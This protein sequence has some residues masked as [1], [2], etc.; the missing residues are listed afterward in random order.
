MDER[1]A[2]K[3][4]RGNSRECRGPSQDSS[5]ASLFRPWRFGGLAVIRCSTMFSFDPSRRSVRAPW[6]SNLIRNVQRRSEMFNTSEFEQTNPN[7]TQRALRF[8]WADGCGRDVSLCLTLRPTGRCKT[9]AE[10]AWRAVNAFFR[11]A[12]SWFGV[13]G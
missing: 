6:R 3:S 7:S 4:P 13:E 5:L 11:V 10:R 12:T 2:A 1:Q 9:R 8:G